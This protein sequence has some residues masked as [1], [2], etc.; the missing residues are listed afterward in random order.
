MGVL[1]DVL[2]LSLIYIY[3]LILS[4]QTLEH[5]EHMEPFERLVPSQ[6]SIE[7]LVINFLGLLW[8]RQYL[9]NLGHYLSASTS[10]SWYLTSNQEKPE[11]FLCR[12]LK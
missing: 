2:I 12:N 3:S 11:H 6:Q 4:N 1:V 5:R 10:T 7:S 9:L 8:L